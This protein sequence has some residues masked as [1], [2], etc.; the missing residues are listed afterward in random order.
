MNNI[1]CET[2]SS[3]HNKDKLNI[4][5]YL[6]VKDKN[7][8]NLYYWHCEKYKTLKCPARATTLLNED[9]HHLQNASEHNHAAEASRV[10][11]VKTINVLKE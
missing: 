3:I 5:G 2:V 8:K 6:M 10:N 11:V 4:H 7:R 9:Q 1:I